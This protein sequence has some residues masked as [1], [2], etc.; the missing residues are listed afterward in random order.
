VEPVAPLP[1]PRDTAPVARVWALILLAAVLLGAC[2]TAARDPWVL[3]TGRLPE[4]RA[5]DLEGI[6]DYPQALA[7]TLDIME[8]DLGLPTL[9]VKFAFLPDTKQFKVLLLGIGYPPKLARDAARQM[10]AIGGHRVVLINQAK[11]ERRDWPWRVSILAHELGH[12]L[13]YEL[14]G[15][16]R[17]TSAQWLREGFAEWLKTSVME[18][19]GREDGARARSQAMMRMRTHARMRFPLIGATSS[20]PDWADPSHGRIQFPPLAGLSSFPD[21]VEQSRGE[22]GPILYDLAFIAVTTLLEEHGVPAVMR[23]FELFAARQDP[24]A[25]FLEAFGESEEQFDER[26]RQIVGS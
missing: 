21:W 5:R 15:G 24:A 23:Y 18:K 4:R 17:G 19:L 22:V 26:L 10:V 13:Q 11:L 2:A 1:Q 16:K 3:T 12:V 25:S 7:T 8:R 6:S 9:Q 14:G 20:L